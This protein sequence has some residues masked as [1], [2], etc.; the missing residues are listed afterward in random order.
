VSIAAQQVRDGHPL[1]D[2]DLDRVAT[3]ARGI[4]VVCDAAGVRDE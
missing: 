3:A 2:A 4:A 1:D